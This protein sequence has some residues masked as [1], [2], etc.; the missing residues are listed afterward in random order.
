MV[1]KFGNRVREAYLAGNTFRARVPPRIFRLHLFLPCLPLPHLAAEAFLVDNSA[2]KATTDG[3]AYRLSKQEEHRTNEKA[4]WGT[5][6]LGVDQGDGWL[7]VGSRYLPFHLKG[8]T[9][10]T[11]LGGPEE[12]A[13]PGAEGPPQRASP[14]AG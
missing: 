11:P 9:V 6:V 2:L 10:L 7:L 5:V 3:I 4:A 8:A 13:T 14:P 1:S 12:P